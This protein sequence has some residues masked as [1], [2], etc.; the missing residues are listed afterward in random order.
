MWDIAE[1]YLRYV[2]D[3]N[4][5][6]HATHKVTGKHTQNDNMNNND[7]SAAI[8]ILKNP[9]IEKKSKVDK[10]HTLSSK[11]IGIPKRLVKQPTSFKTSQ[12]HNKVNSHKINGNHYSKNIKNQKKRHIQSTRKSN[13][14]PPSKFF[15]G[16]Q[17]IELPRYRL[18]T[19]ARYF[20][21]NWGKLIRKKS[22]T[23]TRV[24]NDL[25]RLVHVVI[26]L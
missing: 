15:Y 16:F 4:E 6:Q 9:N 7:N 11:P 18:H 24:N 1:I 12:F 3:T 5:R 2:I 17:P 14:N 19:V 10:A 22:W 26:S 8:H 25:H 20:S 23:S 13:F 21:R